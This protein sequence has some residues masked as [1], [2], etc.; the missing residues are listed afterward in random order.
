VTTA[1]WSRYRTIIEEPAASNSIEAL[2][3]AHERFS[4][5]WDGFVWLVARQPK[6]ISLKK[7]VGG[8]DYRLSHRE[9]NAQYNLPDIAVIFLYDDDSVTIVDV[10][11]WVLHKSE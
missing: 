7:T 5:Q 6:E 2:S 4:D 8:V 1:N 11:V 3:E 10:S 9:G